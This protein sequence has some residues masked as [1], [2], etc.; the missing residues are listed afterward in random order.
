L[1]ELRSKLVLEIY[2]A[3]YSF[4][5]PLSARYTLLYFADSSIFVK[6]GQNK[7]DYEHDYRGSVGAKYNAKAKKAQWIFPVAR[8]G[9]S[10]QPFLGVESS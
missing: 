4:F 8:I 9:T 2:L 5:L 3:V 1:Q 6:F 10:E 7:D